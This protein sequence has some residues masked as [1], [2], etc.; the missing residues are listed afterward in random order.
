MQAEV[1]QHAMMDQ[2]PCVQLRRL[3]P[4]VLTHAGSCR[5]SDPVAISYSP[6]D[7]PEVADARHKL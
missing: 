4:D 7:E 6:I 5:L 2:I 1:Q 3:A